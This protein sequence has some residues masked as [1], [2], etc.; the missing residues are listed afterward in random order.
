[1]FRS[2]NQAKSFTVPIGRVGGNRLW[3]SACVL[4]ADRVIVS[5]AAG[6]ASWLQSSGCGLN[7]DDCATL[8][9]RSDVSC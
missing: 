5:R 2:S 6:T 3:E 1:M 4:S 7:A 9:V 8:A